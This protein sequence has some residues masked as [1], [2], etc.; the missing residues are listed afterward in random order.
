MEGP[1]PPVTKDRIRKAFFG[2]MN[3][4]KAAGLSDINTEMIKAAGEIGIKSC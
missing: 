2:K 3:C 1:P 4:G